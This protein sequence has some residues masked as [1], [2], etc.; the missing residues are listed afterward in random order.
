VRSEGKREERTGDG[1]HGAI[2]MCQRSAEE[3]SVLEWSS[4]I[5]IIVNGGINGGINSGSKS[6]SSRSSNGN[7]SDVAASQATDP[8][9]AAAFDRTCISLHRRSASSSSFSTS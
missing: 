9:A 5:D 3:A 1:F 8:Y 7:N 6:R 4:G 2:D